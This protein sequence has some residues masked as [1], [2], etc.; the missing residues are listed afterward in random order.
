LNRITRSIFGFG[1]PRLGL[2]ATLAAVVFGATGVVLATAAAVRGDVLDVPA[3]IS[4]Q[5]LR[6]PISGIASQ[7]RRA[8][9]VG[10]R[11]IILLSRDGGFNWVQLTAPVSAD[12][13]TVRFG[14]GNTL[15]IL[16]HDA[17]VLRSDDDGETW[18]RVMDGR[19]LFELLSRHYGAM[20]DAGNEEAR[21]VL[22]DIEMAVK[23][24]ATPGV[25]AY[26]FL[27]I[28]VNERGEGFL[29]GAFGLLLRTTD[30]GRTWEP[31]IERA[32]NG[33]RMHLYAIEASPDGGWFLAGEQG[34]VRRLDRDTARFKT[35]E[36]PYQGTYFGITAGNSKLIAYGLRGNAFI[37]RDGA[38]NW[39]SLAIGSDASLVAA[40][41]LGAGRLV[42]VTQTGQV[43]LSDDD[44]A[45]VTAF[46]GPRR[47]EVF[48][49]AMSGSEDL[50]LGRVNGVDRIR[51]PRR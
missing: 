37:S 26:P 50:L 48:T 1:G 17:L 45:S 42:F 20:A 4:P 16:G 9:A 33:R 12:L 19:T 25:L 46:E 31:W 38:T 13:T 40:F 41:D 21:R 30:D 36:M 39:S 44:G 51:L 7:N 28:G 11:G 22:Q 49:A 3:L 34:L 2:R 24:S 8:V 14:A 27:D 18:S 6:G 47:G 10:P 23:Q 29:V 5:A 43:L 35:V 15:W 32:D